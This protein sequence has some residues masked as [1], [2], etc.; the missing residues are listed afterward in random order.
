[1]ARHSSECLFSRIF[2]SFSHSCC[3]C[4]TCFEVDVSFFTVTRRLISACIWHYY[5]LTFEIEYGTNM[6][7]HLLIPFGGNAFYQTSHITCLRQCRLIRNVRANDAQRGNEFGELKNGKMYEHSRKGERG[8]RKMRHKWQENTF[9]TRVRQCFL[10][11]HRRVR[12]AT[13]LIF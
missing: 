3:G 1:M 10:N 5:T 8:R 13:V 9:I 6:E 7:H 2:F 4:R 11:I 12:R